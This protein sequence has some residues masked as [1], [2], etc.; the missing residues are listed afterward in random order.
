MSSSALLFAAFREPLCVET[1]STSSSSAPCSA[2]NFL[3]FARADRVRAICKKRRCVATRCFLAAL[4]TA[5][6]DASPA[7]PSSSRLN[8]ASFRPSFLSAASRLTPS[9]N[10]SPYEEKLD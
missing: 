6:A 1:P 4:A 3:I 9:E 8:N 5:A 7:P 10:S 2:R